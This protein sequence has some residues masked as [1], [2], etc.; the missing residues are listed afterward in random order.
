MQPSRTTLTS[1]AWPLRIMK[2][3]WDHGLSGLAYDGNPELYAAQQGASFLESLVKEVIFQVTHCAL[4]L[5]CFTNILCRWS[6]LQN[7]NM[8][9][10]PCTK[11]Y[12]SVLTNFVCW[13]KIFFL[14]EKVDCCRE[15]AVQRFF[16]F[17]YFEAQKLNNW[18]IPRMQLVLSWKATF[19]LNSILFSFE[20][21]NKP[22]ANQ[23]S[24]NMS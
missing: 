15:F 14:N 1:T 3:R 17:N 8:Y 6:I 13:Q 2:Y 7:V 18:K 4:A 5:H 9:L 19:I 24:L 10:Q 11:I 20:I 12:S 22:G 23:T 21:R 16:S